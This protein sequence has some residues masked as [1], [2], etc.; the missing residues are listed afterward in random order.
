MGHGG[1][2]VFVEDPLFFLDS[3]VKKGMGR[4]QC[5]SIYKIAPV[6]NKIRELLGVGPRKWVPRDTLVEMW[7]GISTDESVRMKELP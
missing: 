6:R 7:M 1:E 3:D 4:R 2:I 5:T